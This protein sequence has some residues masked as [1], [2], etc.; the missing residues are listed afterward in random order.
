MHSPQVV[1]SDQNVFLIRSHKATL[2]EYI[3]WRKKNHTWRTRKEWK[4]STCFAWLHLI[5]CKRWQSI[6]PSLVFP[7]RKHFHAS[8]QPPIAITIVLAIV[9]RG[10]HAHSAT[11]VANFNTV[12]NSSMGA[13]SLLIWT[14]WLCYA[15]MVEMFHFSL[16]FGYIW[17]ML[18]RQRRIIFSP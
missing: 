12:Y 5:A 15:T 8:E 3:G 7:I 1:E 9:S 13:P 11:M 6:N 4:I 10:W 18:L 17:V 2:P 14:F 16:F